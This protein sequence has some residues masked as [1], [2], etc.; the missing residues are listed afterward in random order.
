MCVCVYMKVYTCCNTC[1]VRDQLV[2]VGSLLLL[3]RFQGSKDQAQVSRLSNKYLFLMNHLAGPAMVLLTAIPQLPF[4][5][6]VCVHTYVWIQ[7]PECSVV[8]YSGARVTG[9]CEPLDVAAGN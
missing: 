1:G 5:A 2:G 3:G 4:P 6:Q 8:E 9:D 7:R